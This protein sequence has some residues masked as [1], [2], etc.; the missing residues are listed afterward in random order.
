MKRTMLLTLL[1]VVAGAF[2]VYAQQDDYYVENYKPEPQYDYYPESKFMFGFGIGFDYGG[3]GGRLAALPA[4]AVLLFAG[5]GYNLNDLGY[6]LGGSLRLLPD[7]KV[8]PLLDF[9]YGY[10]AVILV[11]GADEYNKTY[12]GPSMGGGIELRSKSNN[13]FFKF[14]L[15]VP[16]RSQ[17][18]HDDMDFLKSNPNI[19]ISEPLPIAISLGYHYTF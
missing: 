14:S 17:D 15:L 3:F 10:N 19:Q 9:M 2:S 13:N 8:C 18:F 5:F 12:Y 16:F 1:L 7:K 6:N 4:K 11:D